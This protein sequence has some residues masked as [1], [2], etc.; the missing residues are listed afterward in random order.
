MVPQ[1]SK[2]ESKES[3][4]GARRTLERE[5]SPPVAAGRKRWNSPNH[6]SQRGQHKAAQVR[7]STAPREGSKG[8]K[9]TE[10][11]RK[12]DRYCRPIGLSRHPPDT[13]G[14]RASPGEEREPNPWSVDQLK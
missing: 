12:R 9:M 6:P 7:I 3:D 8:E 11:T 5:L 14:Q 13:G 2:H 1:E 10:R 4:D